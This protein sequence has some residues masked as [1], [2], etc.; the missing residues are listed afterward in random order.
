MADNLFELL[1]PPAKTR[2]R[3]TD[4]ATSKNAAKRIKAGSQYEKLV[5]AADY[6]DTYTAHELGKR[7]G[8]DPTFGAAHKRIPEL[9]AMEYLRIMSTRVC[10]IS[11]IES[12]TYALTPAGVSIKVVVMP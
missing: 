6:H 5:C 8:L 12:Q 10:S 4:P 2:A 11:G 3:A 1:D 7:A 9:V